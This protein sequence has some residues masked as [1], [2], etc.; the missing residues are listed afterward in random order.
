[1]RTPMKVYT[2]IPQVHT[3][4]FYYRLSVPIETA[5]MLGLPIKG[6]I[7]TNDAAKSQQEK[8]MEFCD[9]DIITL[10]QPIGEAPLNNYRSL[11]GFLPSKK[12]GSWKY[13]P[14]LIVETDDN[15]LNVSPLNS[16]FKTL[17]IRDMD[18]NQIPIGHHIGVANGGER[19]I[20]WKD[21]ENGF[22]LAKNRQTIASYLK[23]LETVDQVQCSTPP[24]MEAIKKEAN[25]RRIR[26]FPNLIRFDH[27][28]Q[29][30]LHQ[31]PSK[32]NILWAGGQAHYEDWFPLREAIG[33]ITRKYPQIHWNI[34]GAQY[35]W[36]NELIPSH[37]YTFHG[38]CSYQEYKLRLV[39]MNH[40]IALAPL[41][42]NLF[43]DSRS[44]IKWYE[45][46]VMKKPAATLAQNT[47]SYAREMVDG[48][49]GLLF[50][51]PKEFEEKLSRL[52]EDVELRKQ[53][54]A[55]SKDWLTENRDAMK[56]VPKMVESWEQLRYDRTLEQPHPS[57]AQWKVIEAEDVEE[58]KQEIEAEAQKGVSA[59]E[60]VPA[61]A[62]SG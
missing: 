30:A 32:V 42:S 54:A 23:I 9:A 55:N 29:V 52:I 37:R 5:E 14:T 58:Q 60:P 25:T 16:A 18:G 1:M 44:A 41:T 36:V 22:S 39:M 62:E 6:V 21:G 12:D 40:D 61:L 53:L 49:T 51:D 19:K 46:S 57:E 50:D 28:P 35:P 10:Y 24:V 31:D 45:A 59:N 17:G 2:V 27:Y 34:W 47:A 4:S 43:N 3:A 26:V 56:E 20:L 8:I 33:N 15:L 13:P 38:W 7:D 48:V 11:Q